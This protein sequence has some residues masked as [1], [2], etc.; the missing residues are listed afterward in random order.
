MLTNEKER[1]LKTI[2]V[3][4]CCSYSF[5][6]SLF[7]NSKYEY[8][9]DYLKVELP[10]F[11]IPTTKK[12]IENFYPN[13]I[14]KNGENV[15]EITGRDLKQF[16]L[17]CGLIL[18]T[19]SNEFEI[20]GIN[21]E[22]L[23][24][25]CCKI[26]YLKAL[27]LISGSFYYNK[28]NNK[29]SSGYS[30]EFTL[31]NY[32]IADDCKALMKFLNFKVGMSKRGNSSI[33]YLK[34]S[35]TI[36][37]FFVTLGAVETAIEIQNNLLI[38]ELRND[39]NRQ[40]NCFDANLTKTINA[41][42]EQVKAISYIIKNYGLEYL[43]QN[44]QETALLRLANPEITLNEMQKLYSEKITRAGLKYKLD[45]IIAIYKQSTNSNDK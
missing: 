26:S 14:V 24:S 9:N 15:I 22:L 11:I 19:N 37:D 20:D 4:N 30:I 18:S 17:D 8:S 23:A 25:D 39:A 10:S 41:S 27:Y 43:P 45:K 36:Y 40:S 42:R 31:K 35:Q 1:I 13:L 6:Y 7:S 38:R 29:N 16:L 21:E 28:D 32:A 3:H 44:L 34:D 5:L 33:I 12:I 2:S